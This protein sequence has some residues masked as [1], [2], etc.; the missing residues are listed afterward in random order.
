MPDLPVSDAER[1]QWQVLEQH[2]L[3]DKHGVVFQQ[4]LVILTLNLVNE[5]IDW[6]DETFHRVFDPE[7]SQRSPRYNVLI[8][9]CTIAK[10]TTSSS[11]IVEIPPWN[12]E[13][14]QAFLRPILPADHPV[15]Q[16]QWLPRQDVFQSAPVSVISSTLDSLGLSLDQEKLLC[17]RRQLLAILPHNRMHS[18]LSTHLELFR[19]IREVESELDNPVDHRY[20][21]VIAFSRCQEFAPFLSRWAQLSDAEY[22]LSG[23]ARH[24]EQEHSIRNRLAI[25]LAGY[26]VHRQYFGFADA[27]EEAPHLPTHLSRRGLR[28]FEEAV[29][30]YTRNFGL[31]VTLQSL[32]PTIHINRDQSQGRLQK[33]KD[34]WNQNYPIRWN[35]HMEPSATSKPEALHQPQPTWDVKDVPSVQESQG[36]WD[37]LKHY[38][39]CCCT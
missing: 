1:T 29:L 12:G 37:A 33:W 9:L 30:S 17:R 6:N 7:I 39:T 32:A 21:G 8:G 34:F 16:S 27:T 35:S 3:S 13:Q 26:I 4:L 10:A 18:T 38:F 11:P 20:M 36:L 25:L 31:E 23:L 22:L 2:A 28:T 14:P 19:L 5:R 24:F 15:L